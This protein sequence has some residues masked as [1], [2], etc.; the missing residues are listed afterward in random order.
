MGRDINV[1][2][3]I[4]TI[5]M[6]ARS[7]GSLINADY[8]AILSNLREIGLLHRW[9]Q[10][11]NIGRD[12]L[13]IHGQTSASMPINCLDHIRRVDIFNVFLSKFCLRVVVSCSLKFGVRK[14]WFLFLQVVAICALFV[15]RGITWLSIDL[16]WTRGRLG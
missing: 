7:G 14:L 16:E 15:A 2:M 5:L 12:L 11:G 13:D 10:N 4:S 9:W 8:L 1:G 6:C 3:Q